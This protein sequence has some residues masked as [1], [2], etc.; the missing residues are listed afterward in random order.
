MHN[1]LLE[2]VQK[3]TWQCC[4]KRTL[5]IVQES[6]N[7]K[8]RRA[9]VYC[10]KILVFRTFLKNQLSVNLMINNAFLSPFNKRPYALVEENQYVVLYFP[11]KHDQSIPINRSHRKWP[12]KGFFERNIETWCNGKVY[13]INVPLKLYL[14]LSQSKR[15]G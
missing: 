3:N 10:P 2:T 1:C 15:A 5:G 7:G 12:C 11:K 9:G 14:S 6:W 8:L 4:Q 13:Q